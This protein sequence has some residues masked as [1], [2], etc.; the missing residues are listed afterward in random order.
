MVG[1]PSSWSRDQEESLGSLGQ[2]TIRIAGVRLPRGSPLASCQPSIPLCQQVDRW[3]SRSRQLAA[4]RSL[5]DWLGCVSGGEMLFKA[6]FA[7]L[8]IPLLGRLFDMVDVNRVGDLAHVFL[9]VGGMLL[10]LAVL[11]ALDAALRTPSR[12][13]RTDGPYAFQARSLHR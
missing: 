2:R 1:P 13:L 7:L 4:K 8:A 12:R 11:K 5:R 10:L 9:L 3:G 6:V